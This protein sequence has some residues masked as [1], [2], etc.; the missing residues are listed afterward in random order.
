MVV[1]EPID[2]HCVCR[3][4][5]P[6]DDILIKF[7][8]EKYAE[9]ELWLLYLHNLFKTAIHFA[10]SKLLIQGHEIEISDFVSHPYEAVVKAP[11]LET[12]AALRISVVVL[13]AYIQ[14]VQVLRAF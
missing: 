12:V 1:R 2:C 13:H 14:N 6:I 9:E 4:R 3:A 5:N 11:M 8:F 7:I 10:S